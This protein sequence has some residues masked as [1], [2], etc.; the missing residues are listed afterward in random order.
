MEARA[1]TSER[2]LQL[3]DR[4]R[5]E[6]LDGRAGAAHSR[7][8]LVKSEALEI[9]QD[10]YLPIIGV[11]ARDG[12]GEEELTLAAQHLLAGAFAFR[13][14][15]ARP[16]RRIRIG[17]R[18]QGYFATRLAFLGASILPDKAGR[19]MRKHA[20]QPGEPFR[21]SRALEPSEIT[22]RFQ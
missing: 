20:P 18:R 3:T 4:T 17:S 5:P 19:F 1:E 21:L 2:V 9:T 12:F 16:F 8:D 10:D 14:R 11:Q 22:I 6:H 7:C 15:F 13:R